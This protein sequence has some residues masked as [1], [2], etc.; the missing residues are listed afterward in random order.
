MN[1]TIELKNW[2]M[3]VIDDRLSLS[4]IAVDHP[5]LGRNI[6]L[7][8][9]SKI[10]SI[11][12]DHSFVM[13][14]RTLNSVYVLDWGLANLSP[15]EYLAEPQALNCPETVRDKYITYL[16]LVKSK[17]KNADDLNAF[18]QSYMKVITEGR[19]RL[20]KYF[21]DL[22]SNLLHN[23]LKYNDCVYMNISSIGRG[24][25]AAYNIGGKTGILKPSNNTGCY[26]DTIDYSS[27]EN[28]G[29]DI[30]LGYFIGNSCIDLY[31]ISKDIKN[32]VIHNDKR[33]T[34]AINGS[35]QVRFDET[36]MIESEK[37]RG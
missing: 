29:V 26:V 1:N 22:D 21:G 20:T 34:V 7:A 30:Q 16:Q 19:K 12:E 18:L 2:I 9:T 13:T 24:S 6:E 14:C 31:N 3:Y 4:G 25:N 37:I 27:D 11:E 36:I 32:I 17:D 10:L 23:A 35:Y 5:K 28:S 33:A 8:K 15:K